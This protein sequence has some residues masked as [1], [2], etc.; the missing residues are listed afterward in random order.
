M[1]NIYIIREPIPIPVII[2]SL[3]KDAMNE[4]AVSRCIHG[5]NNEIYNQ[6]DSVNMQ[7]TFSFFI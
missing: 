7:F 5:D 3:A 1:S 2:P 4:Y 6:N